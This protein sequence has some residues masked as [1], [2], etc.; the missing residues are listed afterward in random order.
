M[1]I[2]LQLP[3]NNSFGFRAGQYVEFIL[4]DGSRRS[5]SMANAPVHLER[6]QRG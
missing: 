1:V 5:Y 3:A 4:K 6:R 2:Q